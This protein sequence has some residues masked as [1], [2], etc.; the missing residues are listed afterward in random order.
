MTNGTAWFQFVFWWTFS[1]SPYKQSAF[2]LP[3]EHLT[4][5]QGLTVQLFP[6]RH[7]CAQ[8][9]AVIGRLKAT[10]PFI[11]CARRLGDNQVGSVSA[12]KRS[13][14]PLDNQLCTKGHSPLDSW[15]LQ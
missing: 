3:R 5:I 1:E 2:E 12:T 13:L 11:N 10:N 6:S 8:M 14:H 7:L 9:F 4:S 15:Q